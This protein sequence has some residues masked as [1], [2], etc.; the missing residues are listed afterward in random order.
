MNF[1]N[2]N[3]ISVDE[4]RLMLSKYLELDNDQKDTIKEELGSIKS[5]NDLD[6]LSYIRENNLHK[7]FM[8]LLN[9]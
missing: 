7:K 6:F 4:I 8:T 3:G 2:K 5:I 1:V 9:I